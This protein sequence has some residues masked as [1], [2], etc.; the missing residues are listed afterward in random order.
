M[1]VYVYKQLR[2]LLQETDINV[3]N[4][5]C[6]NL[7]SSL[8]SNHDTI[9]FGLYFQ[10]YYANNTKAWAYCCRINSGINT[11]MFIERM[12]RTLKYIYLGGKVNK[13]LDK[14]INVLMKFVRD[15]LFDKLIVINKGKL[16]TKIKIIR[17]RH[18]VSQKL[19]CKSVLQTDMGWQVP[20]CFSHGIYIVEERQPSCSCKL[21]CTDCQVCFHRLHMS[22]FQYKME[23]VQTCSFSLY[24]SERP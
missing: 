24:I 2:T 11:N 4:V 14:A 5:M 6:H 15:K 17:N 8:L 22:G 20:S 7:L 23:H 16:T 9:E 13:C 3:F 10:N 12:H 19:D 18:K 1:Y 21:I